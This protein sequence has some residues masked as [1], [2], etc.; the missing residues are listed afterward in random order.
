VVVPKADATSNKEKAKIWAR[1]NSGR[2]SLLT[3][4][5]AE[6]RLFATKD[7]LALTDQ[8][9]D[10]RQADTYDRQEEAGVRF[11]N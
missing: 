4:S 8:Q 11:V 6:P 10:T 7:A 9:D 1:S 5:M 3:V 2:N